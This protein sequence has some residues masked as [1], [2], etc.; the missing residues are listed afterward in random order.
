[1][2]NYSRRILLDN[3]F[4]FWISLSAFAVS[5]LLSVS[6]PPSTLLVITILFILY[7]A[8]YGLA[9]LEA[10]KSKAGPML[11]YALL[12][13]DLLAVTF[14]ISLTGS[15]K[16]PLYVLYLVVFGVCMYHQSLSN[17][18]FSVVLGS[19]F[20][21]ALPYWSGE[22]L[23]VSEVA[24]QLLILLVLTGVFSTVL[25]LMQKE[26][27]INQR[28]ISHTL[29]MGKIADLLSASPEDPRE[30]V[31][32]VSKLIEEEMGPEGIKCRITV[33][34][35]D[36]GFLPPSGGRMGVHI[37]IVA[38][39]FVFGT[40]IVGKDDQAGLSYSEQNFFSSVARS[41]GQYLHRA[42]LWEALKPSSES[43][44]FQSKVV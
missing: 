33:H 11:Q 41:L 14:A 13:T 38:G 26:R 28:L 3:Q 25:R 30:T 31:R 21:A 36:Q 10:K 27:Q 43:Q 18:V 15:F 16:S 17:F 44:T 35:P 40:L 34:K 24:A 37:P 9:H 20:Y 23:V 22:Q 4:R 8:V 32:V 1:L 39:E 12:T 2:V 19:L 7:N 29:T 5:A 42:R 6:K